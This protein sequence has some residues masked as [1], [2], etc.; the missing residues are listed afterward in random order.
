MNTASVNSDPNKKSIN[1][2]NSKKARMQSQNIKD[3]EEKQKRIKKAVLTVL[4]IAAT[5]VLS[6]YIASQAKSS[7]DTWMELGNTGSKQ[8]YIDSLKGSAGDVGEVGTKGDQGEKGYSSY[9]AWKYSNVSNSDKSENDYL[10]TLKGPQGSRGISA[11]EQWKASRP[12]GVS[13]TESDFIY[14]KK[15]DIGE[16]GVSSFE[17]WRRKST[18]N[19]DKTE[20]EYIATLKGVKGDRGLSAYEEWK[21]QQPE[22]ATTSESEYIASL[23]GVKGDKGASAYE[24]WRDSDEANKN[25]TVSDYLLALK[26]DKGDKGTPGGSI[27]GEI[28]F[29]TSELDEEGWLLCDGQKFDPVQYTDLF[30]AIGGDK[31][32]NLKGSTLAMFDRANAIGTTA[33]ENKILLT[34]EYLPNTSYS[35]DIS[36][37][38]GPSIS[39][40]TSEDGIHT[41]E[42]IKNK[43][44]Y[45]LGSGPSF[46]ANSSSSSDALRNET[47]LDA[48]RHAHTMQSASFTQD[49]QSKIIKINNTGSQTSIDNRQ[50]T[51]YGAYYIFAGY[52][53]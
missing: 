14:S 7:Y 16:K 13:S 39:A 36:H 22:G 42:F 19:K 26:G 44:G 23:R 37:G 17:N 25:K 20:S 40:K 18:E 2:V 49:S 38:H 52:T 33:G 1:M 32:P 24:A 4:V 27:P 47:L 15:G 50:E 8:N 9:E 12:K 45:V 5:L 53:K 30:Y 41:H 3:L 35:F 46:A 6:N 31:V 51:F 11:Y 29:F 10:E 48:G 21:T 43:G 34:E 28:R